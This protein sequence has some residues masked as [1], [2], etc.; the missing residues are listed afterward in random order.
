M[1]VYVCVCASLSLSLCKCGQGKKKKKKKSKAKQRKRRSGSTCGW[2]WV[3]VL[4]LPTCSCPVF[5]CLKLLRKSKTQKKKVKKKKCLN[6]FV[7]RVAMLSS[8]QAL[9]LV[10][11]A[12]FCSAE[13]HEV[14]SGLLP[15]SLRVGER[16]GEI[17][18]GRASGRKMRKMRSRQVERQRAFS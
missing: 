15:H 12:W 4:N 17:V 11:Y 9:P 6:R 3:T 18:G 10:L 1:C 2:S 5:V 13:S 16:G 8:K 14:A 7:C